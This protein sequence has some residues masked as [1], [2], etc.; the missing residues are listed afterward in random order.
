MIPVKNKGINAFIIHHTFLKNIRAHFLLG[1]Q[2]L[3]DKI[4]KYINSKTNIKNVI[5]KNV[6]AFSSIF[7][8]KQNLPFVSN[9]SRFSA[10]CITKNHLCL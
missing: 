8:T 9:P 5:M 7:Q 3:F 4:M 10:A 2:Y 6:T 1:L